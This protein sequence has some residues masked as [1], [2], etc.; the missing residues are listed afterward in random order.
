MDNKELGKLGEDIAVEYLQ[1]KGY[2]ILGRNYIKV[3]DSRFKGEID[4]VAR[5]GK[6]VSFVEVKASLESSNFYPEDRVNSAKQKKLVRL[7]QAW[8]DENR[9]SSNTLW[10]IDVVSV[11]FGI[12]AGETR[13]V[14]LENVVSES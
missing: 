10:Q 14:Y 11:A 7:G 6:I 3:W 4:I 1:N 12:G 13:V 9:Y 2:E 8:L 5:K